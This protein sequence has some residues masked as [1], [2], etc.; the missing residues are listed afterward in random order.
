M[1]FKEAPNTAVFVCGHVGKGAPILYVSHDGEGDW[2][3]LCGGVHGED[4]VEE[5]MLV[6]LKDVVER[7]PSLDA[8]AGMC[9]DHHAERAS[10]AGAWVITDEGEE[11]IR[12]WV[13]DFGWA[14]QLIPAG[15]APNEPAFAYT[16]GLH[17]SYGHPELLMFGLG[18]DDPKGALNELGGRV[19]AGQVLGPGDNLA[20]VLVDHAVRLREVFAEGSFRAHVGYAR[21][22][23]EGS[24]FRLLQ[25]LWPDKDG[26]FP[27]E[28][29]AADHLSQRQPLLP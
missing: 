1:E 28:P 17:K 11:F 29:G 18:L 22:F 21:W 23:N 19:K 5:A 6:C 24:R 12:R 25:V 4:T 2:Q 8:L 15:D 14:V 20:G 26:R 9:A 7:D 3:F 27:G 16:V 13:R 10:P